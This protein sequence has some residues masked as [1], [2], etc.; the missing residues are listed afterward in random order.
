MGMKRR[1]KRI[2]PDGT[3]LVWKGSQWV[4]LKRSVA[5]QQKLARWRAMQQAREKK[6]QQ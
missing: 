1:F 2:K 4:K 6:K 3:V 5:S